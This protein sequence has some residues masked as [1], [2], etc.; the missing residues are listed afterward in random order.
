MRYVL[1]VLLAVLAPLVRAETG[2]AL[3][4]AWKRDFIEEGVAETRNTLIACQRETSL[5]QI[6]PFMRSEG[7]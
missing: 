6:M 1:L 5:L 2:T 7:Q 4:R 3:D